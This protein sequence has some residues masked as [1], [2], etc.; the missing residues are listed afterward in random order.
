VVALRVDSE[1]VG[2][3]TGEATRSVMKREIYRQRVERQAIL[4][5]GV[6]QQVDSRVRARCKV[7]LM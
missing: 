2:A 3:G 5:G 4:A 7:K 1:G 6:V